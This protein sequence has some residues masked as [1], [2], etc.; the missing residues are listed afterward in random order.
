[1]APANAVIHI[2]YLRRVNDLAV[3]VRKCSRD[4]CMVHRQEDDCAATDPPGEHE[5]DLKK[6]PSGCKACNLL[7]G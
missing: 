6:L 4:T 3:N 2:G 1:V 5:N 7:E